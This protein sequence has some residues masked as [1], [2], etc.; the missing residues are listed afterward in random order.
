[1]QRLIA[2]IALSSA[3]VVGACSPKEQAAKPDS[4]KVAQTGATGSNG[5]SYDPATHTATVKATEFA[6]AAPDTIQAG[7]T[8]FHLVNDGTMLHH[9][10]I[11][12]VD[13]GK[14]AADVAAAL[15][16]KGPP[17]KWMVEV[18]GPNA[19]DPKSQANAT[20]NLQPGLHV[21]VCFV[22]MPDSVPHFAK[23][24]VRPLTVVAAAGASAEPTADVTVTLADYNFTT[25]GAAKTGHHTIKVVNSGPQ[26]H[27]VELIRLAPGKTLKEFSAWLAKMDGPPPA[28]AIG[29]VAG[30]PP[31][32]ANYFDVDLT[33]GT[34][35]FLCF[36]PDAKDGKPH[37][38]HGMIKEFK[39]E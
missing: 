22:D 20:V 2:T 5:A 16:S 34:Y 31:G 24:M 6:F 21:L 30:I 28:S 9:M 35:A 15:K 14:T 8:T 33:A 32:A 10:Q 27:E 25:T 17:P 12:R 37:L 19:P 7:W 18:G 29:G 23:G 26:P 13:S 36:L 11:V 39:V 38:A 1:M 3:V 4:A